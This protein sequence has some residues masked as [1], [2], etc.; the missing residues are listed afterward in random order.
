MAT[1]G[2]ITGKITADPNGLIHGFARSKKE[3]QQFERQFTGSTRSIGM[4]MQNMAVDFAIHFIARYREALADRL[5]KET[6][7]DEITLV[8]ET[9]LW[10]ASRPGR[11]I[12]R[13]A[14]LFAG[15]FAVMFFASL[16]PYVTVGAFMVSMMLVSATLTLLVIPALVVLLR[17]SLR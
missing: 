2:T 11:G 5:A 3:V 9:L 1:V 17:S 8:K 15:T 12:L 4:A 13:N 14:V 7:A 6:N 16:T 10:T